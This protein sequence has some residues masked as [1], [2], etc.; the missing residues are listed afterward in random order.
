MKKLI[1]VASL[2]LLMGVFACASTDTPPP[3][4][5]CLTDEQYAEVMGAL[6]AAQE[7]LQGASDTLSAQ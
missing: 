2:F 5:H 3:Q 7:T 6:Q 4:G 1:I